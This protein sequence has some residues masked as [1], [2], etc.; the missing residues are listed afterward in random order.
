[1]NQDAL[2]LIVVLTM[3]DKIVRLAYLSEYMIN[4][5]KI[6]PRNGAQQS[7]LKLCLVPDHLIWGG[8]M[9]IFRGE[10]SCTGR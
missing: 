4:I 6:G 2:K 10:I 1:M 9:E 8:V 7:A 3:P 5:L